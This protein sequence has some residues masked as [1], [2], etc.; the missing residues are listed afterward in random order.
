MGVDHLA[1]DS[2]LL[3]QF[4]KAPLAGTVKTRMMPYLS[5][6]QALALHIQLVRHTAETLLTAELGAVELWLSETMGDQSTLPEGYANI[7]LQRGADL[8]QR[9]CHAIGNGLQRA[10]K[11]ILVGSD[12]PG[13]N[14]NYLASALASLDTVDIVLGP[15]EDGGYVLMGARR[16]S[17]E[18]FTSVSWGTGQVLQQTRAHLERMQWTYRQLSLLQDIDCPED[19]DHLTH[20]GIGWELEE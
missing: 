8:G 5:A 6:A 1:T 7:T 17:I 16:C 19:L 9:M 11:V 13:I 18:L 10:E 14:K 12:C 2:A 4:A 20:F 15:A 3:I